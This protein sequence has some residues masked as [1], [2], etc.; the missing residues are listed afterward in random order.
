MATIF[1]VTAKQQ[2]L[3]SL[4]G[5]WKYLSLL[6]I[7][8]YFEKFTFSKIYVYIWIFIF[9]FDFLPTACLHIQYYLKNRNASVSIETSDRIIYNT[10]TGKFEFKIEDITYFTCVSSYAGK[11]APGLYGFGEYRYCEIGFAN[12]ESIILTSLMANNLPISLEHILHLKPEQELKLFA[13]IS[14]SKF[15]PV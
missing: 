12:G 1:K 11:A 3:V 10:P 8:F 5:W 14:K 7:Q 2:L 15:V 4:A 13:F 9:V 6:A